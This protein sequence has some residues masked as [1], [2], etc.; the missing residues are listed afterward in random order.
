MELG[1]T[2]EVENS[3]SLDLSFSTWNV[4]VGRLS[5]IRKAVAKISKVKLWLV[6]QPLAQLVTCPSSGAHHEAQNAGL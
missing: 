3:F 5:E 4:R 1:S 6:P 2:E